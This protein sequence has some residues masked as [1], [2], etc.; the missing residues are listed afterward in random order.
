M[1]PVQ[2]VRAARAGMPDLKAASEIGQ[3]VVHIALWRPEI[4]T[5]FVKLRL[6]LRAA[7]TVNR[8]LQDIVVIWLFSESSSRVIVND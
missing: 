5:R 1:S 6:P 7:F 4:C 3:R 8:P 2:P